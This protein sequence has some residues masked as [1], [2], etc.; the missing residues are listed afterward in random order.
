[1]TPSNDANVD[2]MSFLME[3][4]YEC[5]TSCAAALELSRRATPLEIGPNDGSAGDGRM[6]PEYARVRNVGYCIQVESVRAGAIVP[7]H[8]LFSIQILQ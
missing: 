5:M 3:I 1:M 8:H 7:G 4:S 6:C 2:A